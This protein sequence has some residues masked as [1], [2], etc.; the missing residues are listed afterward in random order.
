MNQPKA[1]NHSKSVEPSLEQKCLPK[2]SWQKPRIQQLRVS[3][4]TAASTG[5][6]ID[7]ALTG[8]AS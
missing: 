4:D 6:G 1:S 3:L 8:S 5:S 7:F 2:T